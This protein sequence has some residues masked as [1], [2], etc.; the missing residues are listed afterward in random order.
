MYQM[1]TKQEDIIE[2][3]EE[4]M[5]AKNR[6]TEKWEKT[7]KELKILAGIHTVMKKRANNFKAWSEN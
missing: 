2:S 6:I 5:V 4:L 1:K 3:K 7:E